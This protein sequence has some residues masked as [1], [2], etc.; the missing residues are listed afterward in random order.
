MVN[1]LKEHEEDAL[2]SKMLAVI[3]RDAPIAF[4][5]SPKPWLETV[6]LSRILA[7]FDE[8]G[9][10]GLRAR[11]RTL[12]AGESAQ[13]DEHEDGPEPEEA[14]E[15]ID[16]RTLDEAEVMLWL[17]CSDFTNPSLDDVLAYTKAQTFDTAYDML[18]ANIAG[19]GRLKEVYE[20]IERPLIPVLRAMEEC[21]VRIDRK[22]LEKLQATYRTELASIEAGIYKAAGHDFNISSPKQLGDVLFDELGLVAKGQKKTSTGQR[23]TRESELE[24]IRDLHPVIGE[25]LKYRGLQKLLSTYIESIPPQLDEQ[26]RLHAKFLQTGTTTGRMA[27]QS[28]NLQN[29]PITHRAGPRHT[30]RLHRARGIPARRAR[31]LADRAAAGRHPFQ[32]REAGRYLPQ[33]AG[34]APGSGGGR[35]QCRARGT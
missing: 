29:I 23:S 17:L 4:N 20:H 7:L 3:R 32:G 8:L 14:R 16:P 34:R 21:G 22:V 25:V 9:F 35:L 1:L 28:P 6:S 12:L 15:D 10:R 27:S 13:D 11:A 31:L 18:I 2:F 30:P 26:D 24:K 19:T 5:L 33:R